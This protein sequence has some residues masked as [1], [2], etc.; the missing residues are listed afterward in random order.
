MENW[1]KYARLLLNYCLSIKEGDKVLVSTTFLAEPLARELYK[2]ACSLGAQIEFSFGFEGMGALYMQHAKDSLLDCVSPFQDLA[3]KTFDAYLVIRAPYNVKEDQDFDPQRQKRKLAAGAEL[4]TI[5][6]D[7]TGSGAMRRNLCQFPTLAAAQEAEMSLEE[8]T[9]FIMH[10]CKLDADDAIMAWTAL[11][12]G[13]QH[14]VDYLNRCS[15]ITYRNAKS[16]ISFSVKDRIWINSDGK[17]NMPS[18]EVYTGPIEDSVNGHIH[19]DVPS[20]YQGKEVK[21]IT[22]E[23]KDGWVV[24]WQ[25]E[26]GAD[27]LDRIFDIEGARRFGEVAVGTNYDITRSTKNILFDEK[28]GG[29]IHMAIG[30]SYKQTG[31]LNQSAI[32][33]DMIADMK[34]GEIIA[35]GNRIYDKGVFII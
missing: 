8:Y 17:A 12:A 30:Q 14:L 33:W 13:Q 29:T 23:V 25:A 10:A 21:G 7:R 3:I 28:I 34:E 16:D 15:T 35:D 24:S 19:F 20:I 26:Q 5:Y 4:N 22:L 2:E 11:G 18:G 1:N 27:L 31:G 6:F 32:H 9:A